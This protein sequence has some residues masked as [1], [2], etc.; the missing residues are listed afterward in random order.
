[1]MADM[2]FGNSL[3]GRVVRCSSR[4][5]FRKRTARKMDNKFE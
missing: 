3:T 1:M 4:E 2:W 5:V